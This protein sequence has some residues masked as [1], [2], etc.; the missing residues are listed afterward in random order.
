L[1]FCRRQGHGYPAA[2]ALGV[3]YRQ[4]AA[5]ACDNLVAHGQT[6]AVAPV[7]GAALVKFFFDVGKFPL[8]HAAAVIPHGDDGKFA[9]EADG[10]VHLAAVGA[11]GGGVVENIQKDLLQPL[12][13]AG[14]QRN[15]VIRRGVV[16][17]DPGLPQQFFI[18]EKGVLQLG[19][20]VHQLDPQI[21]AAVLDA[22]KFQ[23][24]LHHAGEAAGLLGDDLYA[25]QGIAGDGGVVSQR[26]APAG[27]GGEGGAQ[28][29]RD[30]RDKFGTDLVRRGDL[31]RHLVDLIGETADLVVAEF[32]ALDAV[33]ALGDLAGGVGEAADGAHH[34]L[35]KPQIDGGHQ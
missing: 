16:D 1:F 26:L 32:L 4:F 28:L 12:R 35:I 24:F 10:H 29:V 14:D 23:Q 20:D 7:L 3:G 17:L 34:V 15:L 22:G 11:V 6:D 27:D 31:F 8:R 21:K 2:A 30:L 25:L 18:S 33:A 13:V 9:V 19:G 5:V